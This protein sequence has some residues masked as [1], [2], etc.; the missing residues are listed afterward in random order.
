M[1]KQIAPVVP[2][3]HSPEFF[4]F[5]KLYSAYWHR[6]FL[7]DFDLN[8]RR[9]EA[10]SASAEKQDS[11]V[12]LSPGGRGRNPVKF[13]SCYLLPKFSSGVGLFVPC[14]TTVEFG[15]FFRNSSTASF[16]MTCRPPL[17]VTIKVSSG[18]TF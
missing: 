13:N 6:Q 18:A 9:A 1:K 7:F 4:G 5:E 17:G 10:L 12:A 3:Y 15:W 14:P 2:G 8:T 16:G 11:T